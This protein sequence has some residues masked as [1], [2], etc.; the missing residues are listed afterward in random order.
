MKILT[1][2]FLILLSTESQAKCRNINK[3][4]NVGTDVIADILECSNKGALK[5]DIAQSVQALKLCKMRFKIKE[6]RAC[7]ILGAYIALLT[8][9]TFPDVW[10]CS[11][12]PPEHL[13]NEV[14]DEV[15]RECLRGIKKNLETE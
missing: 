13:A 3:V 6:K 9:N 11:Y 7:G 10:G 5:I 4:I 12:R 15:T 1:I 8:V 14:G 2:L